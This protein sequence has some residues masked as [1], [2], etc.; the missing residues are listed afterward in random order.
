MSHETRAAA[1][2]LLAGLPAVALASTLLWLVQWPLPLRIVL[3]G[4]AMG[5]LLVGASYVH[6]RIRAPLQTT[7]SLLQGLREGNY[8]VR[9]RPVPGDD[10]LGEVWRE[11]NQLADVLQHRRL[12]EVE[13]SALLTTVMA[14][15][16]VA[17]LAFDGS[18][19]LRLVNPAGARLFAAPVDALLGRTA[20][21]LGCQ[22]LLDAP[23]PRI[24]SLDFPGASGRW[25]VRRTTFRQEGLSHHLLVLSDVSVALREE[26]RQAWRRLIR[27]I[28]HELNNSLTPIK[29]IAH[30][31]AQLQLRDGAV[32]GEDLVRGLAVIEKRA[33]SLNRF[34]HGYA[35][36]AKLPPPRFTVVDV[37]A[38]AHRVAQLEPHP[39]LSVAAGGACRI[40]A[41]ADQVEQLLINLVR[42]GLDAV[43]AAEAAQPGAGHVRISWRDMPVEAMVEIHVDDDGP[44]MHE[45]AD[46]FVPFFTTKPG[47]SGIG[48]ALC[49]QIADAHHGTVSLANRAEGGCRATVRLPVRQG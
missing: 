28:S 30:S 4:L 16:D 27:V 21:A 1:V 19:H 18:G 2:A 34:L 48:L 7:A 14:E 45:G 36:L 40:E 5:A 37:N 33:D 49:R 12:T 25:E 20:D 11:L 38:L 35:I 8:S 15:L 47:G 43:Q 39:G 10:A 9:A 3:A 31:L 41:D 29:S 44:G 22:P 24:L 23:A 46:V 42:N 32:S 17:V 13:T 6:R 26:E